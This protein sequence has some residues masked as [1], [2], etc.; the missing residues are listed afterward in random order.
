MRKSV[1]FKRAVQIFSV[2]LLARDL[3]IFYRKN[4]KTIQM[5]IK[6][7]QKLVQKRRRKAGR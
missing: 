4:R 6:H 1:K 5:L 7:G 3:F 2:I